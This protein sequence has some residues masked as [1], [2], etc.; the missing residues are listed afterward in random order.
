MKKYL[1]LLFSFAAVLL[2]STACIHEEPANQIDDASIVLRVQVPTETRSS[3]DTENGQAEYNENVVKDVAVLFYLGGQRKWEV[4]APQYQIING[5]YVI[6]VPEAMR[7]DFN[8][9]NEFHIYV[10]ANHSFTAPEQESELEKV[11]VN[12]SIAGSTPD[13]FVMVSAKGVKKVDMS[14]EAGRQLGV[15]PLGRIAAK[16]RLMKPIVSVDGYEQ[17]GD[18]EALFV[19]A[20][21]RGFLTFADTE[22]VPNANFIPASGYKAVTETT[23]G[24]SSS[25]SL[26][27]YSYF[28]KWDSSSAGDRR[29]EFKV[30]VKLKKIGENAETKTYY[31]KV[32]VNPDNNMIRSNYLYNMAVKIEILGSLDDQQPTEV[33]GDL[34]IIDWKIF[35]NEFG[36]PA[37]D[38]LVVSE[39]KVQM[40]NRK[41]YILTYKSSL[42]NVTTTI[43]SVY[44]FKVDPA[45]D[46]TPEKVLIHSG[47]LFYPTITVDRDKHEIKIDSKLPNNNVPKYIDFSVTNGAL[48]ETVHVIQNPSTYVIFTKGTKSILGDELAGT[49]LNNKAIYHI[50]VLVPPANTILGY[51]PLVD[52]PFYQRNTRV[53]TEKITDQSQETANMVSPSF[54]LASQLGATVPMPYFEKHGINSSG[55]LNNTEYSGPQALY[56]Y[57]HKNWSGNEV[58]NYSYTYNSTTYRKPWSA[59]FDCAKYWEIRMVNGQ[60][61]TLSDWRLPTKKEIELIDALQKSETSVVKKIM[62][63]KYYWSALTNAAIEITLPGASQGSATSAYTRCVR[64]VKTDRTKSKE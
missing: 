55:S 53:S 63:G 7:P 2:L 25:P 14:S 64:D 17:V 59:A 12:A 43:S 18:A 9:T 60:P 21:D 1:I 57:L 16:I 33:S 42:P 27:F 50:V 47:D 37:A 54:E 5:N 32:P 48:T 52:Q 10:V 6:P 22:V 30:R 61:E 51:P 24:S 56:L 34:S 26:H 13:S 3:R 62:T 15:F 4:K 39:K 35:E 40:N 49:H 11:V 36:L 38:F 31:Y 41:E 19:R 46:G 23:P 45:G 28:N 58:F 29:P 20:V 8:G 44:Y